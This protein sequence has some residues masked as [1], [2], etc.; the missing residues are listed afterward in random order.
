MA[1][2]RLPP[3]K[4]TLMAGFLQGAKARSRNSLLILM[5]VLMALEMRAWRVGM[6]ALEEMRSMDLMTEFSPPP[7][8]RASSPML[9]RNL[10]VSWAKRR[11]WSCWRAAKSLE[12][13]AS[14]RSFVKVVNYGR[15]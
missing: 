5:A 11:P 1:E 3:C 6:T 12:R 15:M 2:K 14:G 8:F 13:R 10:E 9:P 4:V 7:F